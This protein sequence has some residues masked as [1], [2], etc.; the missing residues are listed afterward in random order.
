MFNTRKMFQNGTN[1]ALLK[2]F[3]YGDFP[4]RMFQMS[5]GVLGPPPFGGTKLRLISDICKEINTFNI[6]TE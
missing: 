3:S 4:K 2:I 6:C 5:D 1:A